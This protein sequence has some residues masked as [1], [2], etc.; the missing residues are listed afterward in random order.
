MRAQAHP[1]QMVVP[2]GN[3]CVGT[4]RRQLPRL[5]ALSNL[6]AKPHDLI[7][8]PQIPTTDVLQHILAEG[9]PMELLTSLSQETVQGSLIEY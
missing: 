2:R 8:L 6:P 1:Q 9:Q 4:C 7:W 3:D 5:E